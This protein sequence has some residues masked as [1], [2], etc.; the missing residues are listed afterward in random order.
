MVVTSTARK[1]NRPFCCGRSRPPG[2]LVNPTRSSAGRSQHGQILGIPRHDHRA[3]FRTIPQ[4]RHSTGHWRRPDS[5]SSEIGCASKGARSMLASAR[6]ELQ[7]AQRQTRQRR[8]VPRTS[9][10]QVQI[11]GPLLPHGQ[12]FAAEV[13]EGSA[14]NA[15]PETLP[16]LVALAPTDRGT[17]PPAR[18][19]DGWKRRC[20]TSRS[21]VA[22][23]RSTPAV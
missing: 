19:T 21:A 12:A 13:R 22:P 11:N 9:A 3:K 4:R 14:S 1:R 2:S 17:R 15:G 7:T 18:T 6:V 8:E 20:V 5:S 10:A 16:L 23:E